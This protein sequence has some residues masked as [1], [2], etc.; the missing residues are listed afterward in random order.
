MTQENMARRPLPL[1]I[2][3]GE[4]P[5]DIALCQCAIDCI[6]Q[7]VH[8]HICIRMAQ[9]RPAMRHFHTT[10]PDVIAFGKGMNVE[11]IA[12]PDIHAGP[13]KNSFRT[14]EIAGESEF[15][16]VFCA[17]HDGHGQACVPG[18]LDIVRRIANMRSV[19]RQD[20]GIAKALGRLC[21]PQ[22]LAG[23][24]SCHQTIRTAPQGIRHRQCRGR[25]RP[26]AKRIAHAANQRR[27]DQRAGAIMDQHG[28]YAAILQMLQRI[29]HGLGTGC[30]TLDNVEP[31]PQGFGP[32][33][34][35]GMDHQ[36]PPQPGKS[37]Q[38]VRNNGL[39]C[40]A[41]PLLGDFASGAGAAAGGDNDGGCRHERLL[42]GLNR[43]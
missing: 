7:G 10:K 42:A 2:G 40:K 5:P 33:A 30:T 18:N 35:F 41:L 11:T 15:D 16:V 24:G 37:G 6:G 32:C 21:P 43:P 26:V 17:F 20:F 19:G 27:A 36:N 29:A 1:R 3:G 12:K 23:L 28:L 8:P 31:G 14:G 13:F 4:M 39:A 25:C 38:R 34:I 22:P 9:K